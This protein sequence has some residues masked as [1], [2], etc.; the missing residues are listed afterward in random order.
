ME[1]RF[2][3]EMFV[4]LFTQQ[5]CE[6]TVSNTFLISYLKKKHFRFAYKHCLIG[7]ISNNVG[8]SIEREK[9]VNKGDPKKRLEPCFENQYSPDIRINQIATT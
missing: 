4:H 8:F 5:N 7:L 6:F 2:I 3:D 9:Q 1:I